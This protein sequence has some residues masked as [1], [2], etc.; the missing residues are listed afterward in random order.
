MAD[1]TV[2]V[3]PL[4]QW[5]ALWPLYKL[6]EKLLMLKLH[7]RPDQ[8]EITRIL[9]NPKALEIQTSKKLKSDRKFPM[10]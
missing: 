3:L 8:A 6:G 1:R 7:L 2:I 10:N 4:V 9:K 5:K